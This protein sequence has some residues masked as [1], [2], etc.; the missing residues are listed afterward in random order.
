MSSLARTADATIVVPQFGRAELTCACVESLRR[1]ETVLWPVLVVD[2]GSPAEDVL[3][4]SER[5]FAATRVVRQEHSGVTAAWNLAVSR[6]ETP[7][8][9]F[10]NNDAL[11]D[12]PAIERLIAPLRKNAALVCGA[13]WRR[14]RMLPA[15]VLQRLPTDQFLQGW[16][17]AVCVETVRR[18]DGFDASMALYWS[19]T[20]FQARAGLLASAGQEPLARRPNLPIRHLGRRTAVGLTNRRARWQAD[21]AAFIAKWSAG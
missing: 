9:V 15:S 21:R 20:D 18:L 13:A 1:H 17:F 10:L 2:D 14:E 5:D 16:C 8:V 6:T 19:D 11:F 7:I 3:A 4:V 12:G